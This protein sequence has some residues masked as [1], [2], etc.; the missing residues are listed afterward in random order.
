LGGS[1]LKT[2]QKEV[3]VGFEETNDAL[4]TVAP[5]AAGQGITLELISSVKRQ[6]GEHLEALIVATVKDAGY[7]D[8]H[9]KVVDKGAWDY[10]LQAR[11]IAALNRGDVA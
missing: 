2:I 1:F 5:L 6:Y 8:L 11:I 10:A 7:T 4:V 3:T 9:V